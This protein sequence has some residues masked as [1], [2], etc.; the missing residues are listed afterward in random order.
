MIE[1]LI[2][3]YLWIGRTIIALF[4]GLGRLLYKWLPRIIYVL[5]TILVFWMVVGKVYDY[6][7]LRDTGLKGSSQRGAAS[8]VNDEIDRD[9]K[10]EDIR[11]LEQN[12]T[13]AESLWFYNASQGSNLLPYDFFL[14]LEQEESTDL[15]RDNLNIN[16]YRYLPQVATSSNPD[17]LP[18]G[19]T[20]DR[21]DGKDYMGF[22]CSAC[23]TSQINYYDKSADR[24]IGLRIDGAPSAAD[25][26]SFLIN[27]AKAMKATLVNETKFDRFA[28]AVIDSDSDYSDKNSI[29]DDLIEFTSRIRTYTVINRP[30]S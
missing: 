4:K 19:M 6:L 29:K 23:H 16:K 22:T 7:E 3:I 5:L 24:V 10:R 8:I 20:K 25:L 9:V 14:H 15:F 12:W 1:K 21:Y 2:K 18:V 30:I 28:N 26:E 27:L 13:K 17:A 11:Y